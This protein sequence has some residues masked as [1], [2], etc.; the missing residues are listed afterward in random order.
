MLKE[1]SDILNDTIK[2]S[3]GVTG[4][5]ANRI[6][7]KRYTKKEPRVEAPLKRIRRGNLQLWISC[8][9]DGVFFVK[10]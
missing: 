9:D 1:Q 8:P 10:Y 2:S 6:P 5:I 3:F 7:K 4:F